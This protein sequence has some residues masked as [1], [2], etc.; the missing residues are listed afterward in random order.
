M[1]DDRDVKNAVEAAFG[2]G[3]FELIADME[4]ADLA[5]LDASGAGPYDAA[6]V[7]PGAA[8]TVAFPGPLAAR[9]GGGVGKQVP[10]PPGPAPSRPAPSKQAQ[11]QRPQQQALLL[12]EL[13]DT[14]F[15]VSVANVVEIQQVPR[16]TRI[17]RGPRWLRGLANLRG[18][19]ISVVDLR[20]LLGTAPGPGQNEGRLIVVRSLQHAHLTGLMVDRVLSLRGATSDAMKKPVLTTSPV[21]RFVRG[22]LECEGQS[23]TVLDLERLLDSGEMQ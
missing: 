19:I 2:P 12:F 10:A 11:Q 16:I 14:R 18:T 13:A 4:A 17:M 21:N 8:V 7:A 15:G 3:A 23:V 6:T 9:Q 22:M 20:L 1:Q 5:A